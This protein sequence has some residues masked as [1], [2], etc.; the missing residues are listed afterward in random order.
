MPSINDP[1]RIAI[2]CQGG[3]T[4]TA[5]TAGALEA[6]FR[7]RN[8]KNFDVIGL[9]GTSGGA[10]CALLAWF[11]LVTEGSDKAADLVHRFWKTGSTAITEWER[12]WINMCVMG[13]QLPLQMKVSPYDSPLQ[14]FLDLSAAWHDGLLSLGHTWVGPFGPRREFVDLRH[15]LET[16]LGPDGFARVKTICEIQ[17]RFQQVL[18]IITATYTLPRPQVEAEWP[19]RSAHIA[20]LVQ[21]IKHLVGPPG[22][23]LSPQLSERIARNLATIEHLND[24]AEEV[25]EKQ[26]VLTQPIPVLLFGA[27]DILS[28]KFKT[29]DS[30][31]V[32]I[33]V[34]TVLAST[35]LPE[36]YRA[37]EIGNQAYYDGLFSQ[38]PPVRNFFDYADAPDGM[39]KPDQIWII[40]VDPADLKKVP[41]SLEAIEDRR[42]ELAGNLSLNQEITAIEAVNRWLG[43]F[44]ATS[45]KKYKHVDVLR[46]TIDPVPVDPMT[47]KT[48][49]ELDY[50]SKLRLD[51][52]F[53]KFL[54]EHGAN[55][56]AQFLPIARAKVMVRRFVEDMW[57]V[58]LSKLAMP[59]PD[60]CKLL[61]ALFPANHT[62]H[63]HPDNLSS[64]PCVGHSEIITF[65]KELREYCCEQLQDAEA[66]VTA[67]EGMA[68]AIDLHVSIEDTIAEAHR[69]AFHWTLRATRR[70][71]TGRSLKV[72]GTWVSTLANGQ[73]VASWVWDTRHLI[74]HERPS[75]GHDSAGCRSDQENLDVVR[76]W[77][78]SGWNGQ[79]PVTMEDAIK[80]YLATDYV[81]NESQL[82]PRRV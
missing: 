11:G 14:P 49:Y 33:D 59:E 61:A 1:T 40:Q 68:T 67:D 15:R 12:T 82:L 28:G 10:M 16:Y 21:E 32:E 17:K 51:P 80:R 9:S 5:F 78:N 66:P 54:M 41:Q 31:R 73:F 43:K 29:F 76:N 35:T 65:I 38:N 27:I 46:L 55:Q 57:N 69:V 4:H 23:R 36:L 6:L 45:R 2:A 50:A 48:P 63:C 19:R 71:T 77:I 30:R 62:L 20:T 56:A 64:I 81:H 34:D 7:D 26:V 24:S 58:L 39:D 79:N 60:A 8:L 72:H 75:A 18:R 3:S 52:P 22:L 42:N 25:L 53:I 74:A 70:R 47:G 13:T 44:D 37:R